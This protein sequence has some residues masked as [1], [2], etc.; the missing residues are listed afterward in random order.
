M[1][2]KIFKWI[3]PFI[4]IFAVYSIFDLIS[5]QEVFD[6][7]AFKIPTELTYSWLD[8]RTPS[9]DTN[10]ILEEI[11]NTEKKVLTDPEEVKEVMK[12]ISKG[13][14][15]KKGVISLTGRSVSYPQYFIM[16]K[17]DNENNDSPF[18]YKIS[19][20]GEMIILCKGKYFKGKLPSDSFRIIKSILDENGKARQDHQSVAQNFFKQKNLKITVNSAAV[21]EIKLPNDFNTVENGVNVGEILKK[22]NELSKQNNL[23]FSIY[24][25]QRVKMYTAQID[26]GEPKSNYDVVLFISDNKVVGYWADEGRKDPKQNYPDF[27]FLI[28]HL[29]P[30]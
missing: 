17:Y 23:D 2:K 8:K 24:M 15:R 9:K 21:Q 5:Y 13:T 6:N 20:S 22:R 16:P 4:T 28:N 1:I 26:T 10:K 19:E 11:R 3:L 18:Y 29:V 25:G 12:E 30:E 7:N 14:F 27:N